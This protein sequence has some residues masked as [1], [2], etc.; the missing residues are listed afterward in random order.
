MPIVL[1][2]DDSEIDRRLIG[3]LLPQELDWLVEYADNGAVALEKMRLSMPDIVITD[4]IM[5]EID[6][7]QL[8]SHIHVEFPR[9]PVILITAH[10]SET[11]AVE[12]LQRGAT[13]YVPKSVL[14]EKLRETVEQVL[15]LARADR[16]Y[17]R[18]LYCV[19]RLQYDFVL[20][21]DPA[22][23]PPLVDMIQQMLAGLGFCSNTDRMH[24]GIA[25]E[26]ALLNA[27]LAGNLEMDP[28]EVQEA[29]KN[30]R[31][32]QCSGLVESRRH[33][34]P[35]SERMT[36]VSVDISRD[37][38]IFA[39]RDEGK[40]FDI[41]A[42]PERDDAQ[43]LENRSGRGL[44]LMKNFMDDVQFSPG[45]NEVTMVMRPISRSA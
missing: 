1:V 43:M 42:V 28:R 22:L 12:A 41:S 31:Q 29:R 10:G 7:M 27:L 8:V 20:E 36:S 33:S 3:G 16:S 44:V 2:V 11:L 18:L 26:E 15:A 34:S 45:G 24:A 32:G 5:P 9:I 25:L 17:S 21:N 4:M 30:L 14:A 6:G 19:Q 38:A 23:V 13:S 35:F 37:R 40:G 39:I